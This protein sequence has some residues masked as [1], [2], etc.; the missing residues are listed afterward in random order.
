MGTLKIFKEIHLG[1]NRSVSAANERVPEGK[2]V[3]FYTNGNKRS[4]P[5][6]FGFIRMTGSVLGTKLR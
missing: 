4:W 6:S 5:T 3:L 2:C 1:V